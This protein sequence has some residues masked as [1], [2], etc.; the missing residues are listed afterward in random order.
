MCSLSIGQSLGH[1]QRSTVDDL[2]PVK[3]TRR[4]AKTYL[5]QPLF[6]ASVSVKI[7][8]DYVP[9]SIFLVG[10]W[11]SNTLRPSYLYKFWYKAVHFES[12]LETELQN[13]SK[14][15]YSLNRTCIA[16]SILRQISRALVSHRQ[17]F[18][19]IR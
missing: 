1:F 9:C 16:S 7:A 5:N 12:A 11:Q 6:F 19:S 8:V 13:H 14:N 17:L 3:N 15:A 10:R 2:D 4:P 18:R